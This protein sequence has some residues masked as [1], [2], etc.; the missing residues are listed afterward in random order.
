ML[1]GWDNDA[2]GDLAA[3]SSGVAL[4]SGDAPEMLIVALLPSVPPAACH[5]GALWVPTWSQGGVTVGVL[6]NK[7]GAVPGFANVASLPQPGEPKVLAFGRFARC[8]RT[9]EVISVAKASRSAE[10]TGGKPM[11]TVCHWKNSDSKRRWG[12]FM[13]C[14]YSALSNKPKVPASFVDA[15]VFA[16]VTNAERACPV[17]GRE[18]SALVTCKCL[19]PF[20]SPR[21]PLDYSHFRR[22][23]TYQLGRYSSRS[24]VFSRPYANLLT[25]LQSMQLPTVITL[26]AAADSDYDQIATSLQALGI[27]DRLTSLSVPRGVLAPTSSMAGALLE[28]EMIAPVPAIEPDALDIGMVSADTSKYA[29]LA[30]VETPTTFVDSVMP[31]SAGAEEG[32][33]IEMSLATPEFDT[34]MENAGLMTSELEC[35]PVPTLYDDVLIPV[36]D[37]AQCRQAWTTDPVSAAGPITAEAFSFAGSAAIETSH[38]SIERLASSSSGSDRQKGGETENALDAKAAAKLER[39]RKN[40]LA[41]ARSNERRRERREGM[42]REL[43][44]LRR[45]EQEL[46][47]KHAAVLAYNASLKELAAQAYME[48]MRTVD[49]GL[50]GVP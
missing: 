30:K 16:D 18:P 17:C 24:S 19:I 20:V 28:R 46:S 25:S 41:A 15:T 6:V 36:L 47:K 50:A 39:Q 4:R 33:F 23:G 14:D 26:S 43:E 8:E 44:T 21:D 49:T 42:K 5:V 45:Q 34:S 40:R 1:S 37:D 7:I 35:T 31:F 29:A 38:V 48:K 22:N 2:A 13:H 9:G 32:D 27:Q 12:L 3:L 10:A 11:V